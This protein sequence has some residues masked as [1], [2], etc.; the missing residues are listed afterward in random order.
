MSPTTLELLDTF[1]LAFH[2]L[3][4]L[5]NS[6]GWIIRRLRWYNLVTLLLTGFSW[7]VMGIWYGWGYC[8]CTDW[9]W[10]V[11]RALGDTDLPISYI[12]FLIQHWTG[13]QPDPYLVDIATGTVFG[14][15]LICSSILN[16][17]DFKKSHS[18]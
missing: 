6:L 9:H 18:T 3:L 16:Y 1:F 15:A 4:I 11:R 7:F 2:T 12:T 10:Q 8:F 5:F 13:F 17:R 14:L